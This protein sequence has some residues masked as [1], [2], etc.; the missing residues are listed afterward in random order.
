MNDSN[1]SL[2]PKG[3]E[4]FELFREL[5]R[6]VERMSVLF[7]GFAKESSDF[8]PYIEKAH[9]IEASADKVAHRI[10]EELNR[11]FITP[12][13]REDIHHLAYEMDEIVDLIEDI[14]RNV[15]LYHFTSKVD[16][17]EGF[18]ECIVQATGHLGK[19]V[20]NLR[21]MKHTP[22]FLK[23]KIAIHEIED[24]ADLLFETAIDRLFRD[25]HDPILVIKTKDILEEME[26]VVDKYQHVGN[27]I[28]SIVI[29]MS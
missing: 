2:L 12:F 7:S 19:M 14:V 23:D 6:E 27:L 25:G 11:S 21:K 1:M 18:A 24:R 4:F 15:N 9:E 8:D 5:Q 26:N 22:E 28:E 10:V 17:M 13:D 16:S 29:K 20:E 3:V